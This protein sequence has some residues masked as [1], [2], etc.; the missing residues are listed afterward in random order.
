MALKIRS[1]CKPRLTVMGYFLTVQSVGILNSEPL[2]LLGIEGPAEWYSGI[3]CSTG[4][5]PKPIAMS[6]GAAMI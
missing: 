2:T 4:T 1:L 3:Q 6:A 5:C